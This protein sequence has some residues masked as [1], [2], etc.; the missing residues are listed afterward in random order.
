LSV[1][2]IVNGSCPRVNNK[3]QLTN[4]KS[5]NMINCD[6]SNPYVNDSIVSEKASTRFNQSIVTTTT[7]HRHHQGAAALAARSFRREKVR[8]GSLKSL[9]KDVDLTS[10]HHNTSVSSII[11]NSNRFRKYQ[12]YFSNENLN[13]SLTFPLKPSGKFIDF[14]KENKLKLLI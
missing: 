8:D 6:Y 11:S 7:N 9:S 12:T 3:Q 10:N 5:L 13:K 2:R 1:E 4:V 14:E